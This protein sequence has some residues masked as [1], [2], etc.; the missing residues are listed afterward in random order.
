M[1]A[2]LIS[3][4]VICVAYSVLNFF[5][6]EKGTG[7]MSRFV[8]AL[9]FLISLV[10]AAAGAERQEFEF[11]F[12]SSGDIEYSAVSSQAFGEA[13][14]QMLQKESITYEKISV[15]SSENADGSISINELAVYG[16]SEKERC[17]AVITENTGLGEEVRVYE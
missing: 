13:I 1:K 17:R 11:S 4:C 7:K 15:S 3:L 14:G 10:S 12:S 16:V 6:T 9:C 2:F 8:C 5:P